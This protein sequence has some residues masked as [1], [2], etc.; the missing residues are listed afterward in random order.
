MNEQWPTLSRFNLSMTPQHGRDRREDR[1]AVSELLAFH[2]IPCLRHCV[3][4]FVPD[5][6]AEWIAIEGT[7]NTLCIL[8]IRWKDLKTS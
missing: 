7:L 8:S 5:G 2:V 6:E 1:R 4:S 3:M